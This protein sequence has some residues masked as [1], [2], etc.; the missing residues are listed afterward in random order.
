MEHKTGRL[1][2][3][4]EVQPALLYAFRPAASC[5]RS[6]LAAMVQGLCLVQDFT[7]VSQ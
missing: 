1:N 3:T 6:R 7:L 2:P 4:K 5:L